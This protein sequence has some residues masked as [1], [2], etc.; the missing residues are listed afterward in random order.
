MRFA[1]IELALAAPL[2]LATVPALAQTGDTNAYGA[3]TS[4][5]YA[6]AEAKL[7]AD[8]RVHPGRPELLL[9]LAAVYA[10]TDRV[11]AARQLYR[12]VLAQDDVLMDLTPERTA[13]S[14]AIAQAG[15]A[16]LPAQTLTSR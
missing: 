7:N 11:D 1:L 2:A 6:R 13:G 10:R 3:I 8:L 12:Q 16:R 9:N 5:D 14:H 15:L 4:G